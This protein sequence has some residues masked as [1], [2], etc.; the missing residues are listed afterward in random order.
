[1][2]MPWNLRFRKLSFS[3]VTAVVFGAISAT[4]YAQTTVSTG[5]I[6]GTVTDQSGAVVPLAKVTITQKTTGR[7]FNRATTSAGAYASGALTPG[8]YAVRVEAKG[9]K[10]T[11]ILLTV[12]VGVTT[13]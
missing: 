10:A 1:M 6:Q 9:F 4:A 11:E 3:L 5:S 12:E 8:E 13:P 2:P 7:V